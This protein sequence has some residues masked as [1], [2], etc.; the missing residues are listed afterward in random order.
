M[1]MLDILKIMNPGLDV[2]KAKLHLAYRSTTLGMEAI[3]IYLAGRFNEWQCWNNPGSFNRELVISLIGLPPRPY[4]KW[5]FA[6]IHRC[7]GGEESIWAETNTYE[8]RHNMTEEQDYNEMNGRLVVDFERPGG[9]L[10]YLVAE[11][12][13]DGIDVSEIYP[14]RHS[15]GEFAG[16]KAVNLSRQQLELVFHESLDSWRAALSSVAGV[17]LISDMKTGKSYV[18]SAYGEG[19]IWGRWS[20]YVKTGHG[21]NVE[22]QNLLDDEGIEHAENFRYAILEIS[23][24]LTTEKEIRQRESHWKDILMTR[25]HGLNAN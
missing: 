25:S 21:S 22:L 4:T 13:I 12:W 9:Q 24:V 6:G 23:D 2:T 14:R 17:Y 11:N 7:Y 8:Y 5:L 16:F 20:E 3:D 15:I 19:G 18:G 10:A 1:R